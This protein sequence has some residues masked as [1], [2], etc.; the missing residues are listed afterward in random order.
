ML[1]TCLIL[2]SVRLHE[3]MVYG[4]VVLK[5]IVILA[6]YVSHDILIHS[7]YITMK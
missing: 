6:R 4:C 7:K 5:N 2:T 3:T 1:H